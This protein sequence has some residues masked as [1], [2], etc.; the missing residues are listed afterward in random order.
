[1]TEIVGGREF[2]VSARSFF[3]TRPD[4]AAALATLVRDAVGPG[5]SVADL[6]AGVGL[7]GALLDTPRALVSVE[8]SGPATRDAR[9][10]LA[11][12]DVRDRARAT[13]STSAHRNRS[14]S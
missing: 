12:L 10:N 9:H 11:H 8:R 14:R 4:G 7:F 6:Y 5:R 2:R 13:S 1:M 3:Q